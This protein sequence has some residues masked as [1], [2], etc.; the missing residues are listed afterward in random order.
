M[1]QPPKKANKP[2]LPA[3]AAFSVWTET[4]PPVNA[5]V[6]IVQRTMPSPRHIECRWG[7]QRCIVDVRNNFHFRRHMTLPSAFP[8]AP[9]D[10][11][12]WTYLGPLPRRP[13]KW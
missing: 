7:E 4:E 2:S 11:R 9:D 13:G 10:L 3:S 8:K 12:L 6:L 5:P 1:S